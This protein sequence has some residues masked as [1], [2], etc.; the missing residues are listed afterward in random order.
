MISQEF[1]DTIQAGNIERAKM[2][3]KNSLT[4]DLTFKQ[5]KEMLEYALKFIPNIIETHD[6]TVFESKEKWN[7]E[8]ASLL[9]YD[10]IDNFSAER[11]EHIKDVQ[12]YVY[13]DELKNQQQTQSNTSTFQQPKRQTNVEVSNS[14][15]QLNSNNFDSEQAITLIVVLGV[16]AASIL[17]GVLKGLSIV[18]VATT[19]IATV[20]VGGITYYIIK[21]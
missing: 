8:Y 19:A 10:L 3:L 11:I 20:V 12:Q 9:K 14:P 13:A 1:K 5:F 15:T 16:G 6:G 17:L 18:K 2:M 21:K 7:K 4:M